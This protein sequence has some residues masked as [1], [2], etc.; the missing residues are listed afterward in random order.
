MIRYL[1]RLKAKKGFT[2]VELIVVIA[3]IAVL[4]AVILSNAGTEN[5]RIQAANAAARDF[6]STVQYSFTKYM[7]YEAALSIDIAKDTTATNNSDKIIHY[8]PQLNGNYPRE[9]DTFIKMFVD[10]NQ[11]Q[12]VKTFSGEGG[13]DSMLKDKTTPENMNDANVL[14]MFDKYLAKDFDTMMESNVDGYYYAHITFDGAAEADANVKS[15]PVKVASAFYCARPFAE[16]AGD[17]TTYLLNNLKFEDYCRLSN[18][19]ICGVCTSSYGLNDDGV[20]VLL[21]EKGTFF[22]GAT[23]GS[24]VV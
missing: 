23:A 17:P 16:F 24:F 3:I 20:P 1:Q 9:E 4:T 2:V 10:K 8:Y 5:E 14:N 18:G 7:K 15:A 22:M 6:Y 12:Y 19:N 13:F 11:I 21:G